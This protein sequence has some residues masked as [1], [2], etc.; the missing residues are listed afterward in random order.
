MAKD[1]KHRVPGF[2][3]KKK[4]KPAFPGLGWGLVTAAILAGLVALIL[5]RYLPVSDQTSPAPPALPDSSLPAPH[6]SF[7]KLLPDT[8][9]KIPESEV[10]SEKREV[11]LGKTPV[12]GQYFLQL[13]AFRS[14]EQAEALKARLEDFAKLKPRL[15]QIKL[16]YASWYRVKLGPY[17]TIPDANQVRLFLRD[18]NIDSIMQAPAN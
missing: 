10:N 13:G 4:P 8:E 17:Q 16:E 12:V 2:Q 5:P 3:Q 9:R 18:R 11:R 7:F 15:E 14:Q 6:F 1:L